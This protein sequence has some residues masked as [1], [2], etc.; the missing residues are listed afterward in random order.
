MFIW[1][2]RQGT[3]CLIPESKERKLPGQNINFDIW[4]K[5]TKFCKAIIFQL[6]NKLI[7]PINFIINFIIIIIK[8]NNDRKSS[9]C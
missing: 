3:V 4:Q 2:D 1:E 5:T 9:K 7:K 8:D 6:K